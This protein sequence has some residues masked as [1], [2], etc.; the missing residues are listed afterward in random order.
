MNRHST[1]GRVAGRK[2]LLSRQ[3]KVV[4]LN[5]T[6]E[7]LNKP[8]AFWVP[9]PGQMSPK[10]NYLCTITGAMFGDKSTVYQEKNLLQTVRHGGGNVNSMLSREPWIP[11]RLCKFFR[12]SGS[13]NWDRNELCNKTT[14]SIPVK[15]L[16]NGLTEIRFILWIGQS[17]SGPQSNRNAVSGPEVVSVCWMSHQP[18]QTSLSSAMNRG[19]KSP[20]KCETLVSC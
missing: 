11:R 10:L 4:H 13:W 8:E 5:F 7:H 1:H 19:Q 18:L 17:K 2:P 14:K 20:Q 6:R 16:W 3:H 9:F 12:E 15:L